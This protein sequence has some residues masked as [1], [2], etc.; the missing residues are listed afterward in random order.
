M[1]GRRGVQQFIVALKPD[2]L[3]SAAQHL[4]KVPTL[5]TCT[6]STSMFEWASR[7]EMANG[8]SLCYHLP[9]WPIFFALSFPHLTVPIEGVCE[10]HECLLIT[11]IVFLS[12]LC[13]SSIAACRP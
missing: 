4:L 8:L 12:C 5:R 11:S 7:L 9:G 2:C 10:R 6:P 1:Y 3:H 13:L